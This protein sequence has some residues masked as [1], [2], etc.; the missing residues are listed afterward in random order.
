M[1]SREF[2]NLDGTKQTE[3][4]AERLTE[5]AFR[6][7]KSQEPDNELSQAEFKEVIERIDFESLRGTFTEMLAKSGIDDDFPFITPERI[8]RIPTTETSP[9]AIYYSAAHAIGMDF[10]SIKASA[11]RYEVPLKLYVLYILSHEE[12][13][14]LSRVECRG[15]SEKNQGNIITGR[16]GYSEVESERMKAKDKD[17][18][19]PH[20][21]FLGFEEGITE[22]I[23]R[24]EIVETYLSAHTD[25]A[26]TEDIGK[27]RNAFAEF[28]Q[29]NY[30]VEL[31]MVNSLIRA[32][33]R[34]TTMDE[35]TVWQAI[36]KGKFSGDTFAD[37][38]NRQ[39]IDKA[40]G[41]EI[42]HLIETLNTDS[43]EQAIAIT[44]R[45]DSSDPKNIPPFNPSINR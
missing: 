28:D 39:L 34:A 9:E 42:V 5:E 30:N 36:K 3:G 37:F 41:P 25:F 45:L 14:A 22:K 35:A 12:V 11:L 2:Y 38:A 20:H 16:F 21:R 33:S 8:I 19:L 43:P 29:N 7:L 18:Y 27:L 17:E 6:T 31:K 1:Q 13:H 40:L 32:L 24:E 44:K 23:A 15:L 4:E 26:S 10:L